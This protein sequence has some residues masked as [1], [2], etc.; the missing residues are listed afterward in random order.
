MLTL[1]KKWFTGIAVLIAVLAVSL[2]L[3]AQE[4][5]KKNYTMDHNYHWNYNIPE[6]Y[7]LSDDQI[8]QLDKIKS[9]YDDLIQPEIEKYYSV[10]KDYSTYQQQDEISSKRIREYQTELRDIEDN[11]YS[12]KKEAASKMRNVFGKD[13]R[14]YY[15]NYVYNDWCDD[16]GWNYSGYMEYGMRDRSQWDGFPG[17]MDCGWGWGYDSGMRSHGRMYSHGRCW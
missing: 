2:V 11:I 13:Q 9:E 6:K 4:Q 3:F 1:N 16:W 10:R 17:Y 8:N 12:L 5:P 15:N 7:Q 14:P